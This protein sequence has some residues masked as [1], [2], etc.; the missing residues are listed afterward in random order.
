MENDGVFP[1]ESSS[2][3]RGHSFVFRGVQTQRLLI[4][5]QNICLHKPLGFYIECKQI[6]QRSTSHGE[7]E[8]GESFFTKTIESCWCWSPWF[9]SAA[10]KM[11]VVWN[12]LRIHQL[13]A[14]GSQGTTEPWTLKRSKTHGYER[15]GKTHRGPKWRGEHH[16]K[17]PS[18]RWHLRFWLVK[19]WKCNCWKFKMDTKK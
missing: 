7:F 4:E 3:F 19:C 5:M 14:T 11:L 17:E 6:I 13:H 8:K 12:A 2:L 18:F 10:K 16:G 9:L 15:F 1:I